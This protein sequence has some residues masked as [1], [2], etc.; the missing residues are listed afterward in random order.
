[1]DELTN[2][3]VDCL[4]RYLGDLYRKCLVKKE[5]DTNKEQFIKY[6][7]NGLAVLAT[8]QSMLLR[9]T[10]FEVSDKKWWMQFYSKTTYYREREKASRTFLRCVM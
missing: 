8:S 1:M 2:Q 9:K 10:Y 6:V 5:L 4:L 7:D 3:E